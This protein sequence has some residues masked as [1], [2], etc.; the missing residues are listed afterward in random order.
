MVAAWV[1]ALQTT[2]AANGVDWAWATQHSADS[3]YV[4]ADTQEWLLEL[5]GLQVVA[6]Q[7]V[8][9]GVQ[10]AQHAAFQLGAAAPSPLRNVRPRVQGAT[11]GLPPGDPPFDHPGV[12]GLTAAEALLLQRP[13][14][15]F[16]ESPAGY[17]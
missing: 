12:G 15:M 4:D 5:P 9:Y 17:D 11:A 2:F 6:Q 13:R 10:Q 3:T 7:M 14:H 1:A 8:L 16:D